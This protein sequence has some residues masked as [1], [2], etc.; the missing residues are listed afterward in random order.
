MLG[1]WI[2]PN[3]GAKF[4]LSVLTELNNRGL[5]EIFIACIDGLKGLGEA[6]SSVYP[7]TIIQ[8]CVVHQIRNSLR[9][10]PHKDK[11]AVAGDLKSI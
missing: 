4:W 5:K 11:K 7:Q 1:I 10:V 9:Y 2:S 3:E 6:I 8:L